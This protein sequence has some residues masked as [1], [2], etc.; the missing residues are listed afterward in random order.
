M[1]NITNYE[2]DFKEI[3]ENLDKL[4]SF[5]TTLIAFT[6]VKQGNLEKKSL[7]NDLASLI[8]Q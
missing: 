7:D 2:L 8:K 4:N 1:K 5:M 6:M 3:S